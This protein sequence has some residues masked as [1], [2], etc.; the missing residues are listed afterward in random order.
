MANYSNQLYFYQIA[1]A[2]RANDIFFAE[3]YAG[4]SQGHSIIPYKNNPVRV[5]SDYRNGS[6]LLTIDVLLSG[7]SKGKTGASLDNMDVFRLS[8]YEPYFYKITSIKNDGRLYRVTGSLM[9]NAYMGY[10][11]SRAPFA[12]SA[13]FNR[14][15]YDSIT[16]QEQIDLAEIPAPNYKKHRELELPVNPKIAVRSANVWGGPS[17][18]VFIKKPI[19]DLLDAIASGDAE[20]ARTAA[21]E[22]M[23]R[24]FEIPQ[25]IDN[26]KYS[27]TI[28]G[29]LPNDS[30]NGGSLNG[31]YD[32][33]AGLTSY[34]NFGS[35]YGTSNNHIAQAV[36]FLLNSSGDDVDVWIELFPLL[37][38]RTPDT[39]G[40][41][42]WGL[43]QTSVEY[44]RVATLDDWNF[45]EFASDSFIAR[46]GDN[47]V[48]IP[49]SGFTTGYIYYKL[50][51]AKSS[52]DDTLIYFYHSTTDSFSSEN[53]TLLG[54][55]NIP[56]PTISFQQS[57]LSD[58]LADVSGNM[59]SV[60]ASIIS[61]LINNI[62]SMLI[63]HPIDA[64]DPA[65]LAAWLAGFGGLF[66]AATVT[67]PIGMGVVIGALVLFIA[68]QIL[69]SNEDTKVAL[70]AWL[71][72]D[73][74]RTY[75]SAYARGER[76]STVSRDVN[77]ILQE[78][79]RSNQDSKWKLHISTP[80]WNSTLRAGIMNDFNING[81]PLK[82]PIL[83]T[84]SGSSLTSGVYEMDHLVTSTLGVDNWD[85]DTKYTGLRV[86]AVENRLQSG[87]FRILK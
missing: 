6:D 54:T 20:K 50:V 38:A 58:Q 29:G 26:I 8:E 19:T 12:I 81:V 25:T 31:T 53:A 70:I 72:G 71:N 22:Y 84:L 64:A 73:A 46:F 68:I 9:D 24:S 69:V 11:F 30:I 2:Y 85:G 15:P 82:H 42:T 36:D 3:E 16:R 56:N 51:H 63:E 76:L 86:R 23:K 75:A 79:G 13:Y 80:T 66:A 57:Y 47:S 28:A 59:P 27:T 55:M 49:L 83:K 74:Y 37:T 60:S 34:F 7:D 44:A 41:S 33:S 21:N 1:P 17:G 62:V 14:L 5:K 52:A 67:G 78:Y 43:E 77:G 39:F 40:D 18:K 65:T 32:L 4:T 61:L 87:K 48:T 35:T 10:A 45:E